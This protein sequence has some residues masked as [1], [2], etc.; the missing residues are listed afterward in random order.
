MNVN[1]VEKQGDWEVKKRAWEVK[2]DGIWRV[3]M[4]VIRVRRALM[5]SLIGNGRTWKSKEI[6]NTWQIVWSWNQGSKD[7]EI[8]GRRMDD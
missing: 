7:I 5:I 1:R 4:K 8:E 2:R 3:K 6:L